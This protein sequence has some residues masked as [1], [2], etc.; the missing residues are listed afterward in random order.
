MSTQLHADQHLVRA[1]ACDLSLEILRHL[2][3][4][5][6]TT[7]QLAER[8]PGV[9]HS[10]V[11]TCLKHLWR[12]GLLLRFRFEVNDQWWANKKGISEAAARLSDCAATLPTRDLDTISRLSRENAHLSRLTR[13]FSISYRIDILR[14]LGKQP[15]TMM[16][17]LPS[18]LPNVGPSVVTMSLRTL[19]EYG[20]LSA[21]PKLFRK[22]G[23]RTC[24]KEFSITEKGTVALDALHGKRP[25]R[26]IFDFVAPDRTSPCSRG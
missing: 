21:K 17:I 8:L 24:A 15:A 14:A 16:E 20:L 10:A 19:E 6:M 13:F 4:D 18:F 12:A 1:L 5:G 23:P 3:A 25:L 7:D 2:K 11:H 26:D 9:T 22:E